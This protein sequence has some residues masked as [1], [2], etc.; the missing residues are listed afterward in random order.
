MLLF[1]CCNICR[2]KCGIE[3]TNNKYWV[4]KLSLKMVWR[5]SYMKK[6]L[7]DKNNFKSKCYEIKLGVG[8]KV[9]WIKYKNTFEMIDMNKWETNYKMHLNIWYFAIKETY[10][11]TRYCY[12]YGHFEFAPH[13]PLNLTCLNFQHRPVGNQH[14]NYCPRCYHWNAYVKKN[15]CI[16]G[17]VNNFF[18]KNI[19]HTH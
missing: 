3:Y 17:N 13:Y 8:V 16:Q 12:Y 5:K 7:W 6:E 9:K 19:H 11:C 15:I 4:S 2:T 14:H 10:E 18:L 1:W